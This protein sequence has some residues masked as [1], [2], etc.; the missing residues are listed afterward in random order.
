MCAFQLVNRTEKNYIQIN[1]EYYM[2]LPWDCLLFIWCMVYGIKDET[3][4]FL[5]FGCCFSFTCIFFMFFCF[6][7]FFRE[8]IIKMPWWQTFARSSIICD[9]NEVNPKF[10]WINVK[11][12]WNVKY[13]AELMAVNIRFTNWWQYYYFD[14]PSINGSNL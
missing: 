4:S 14:F 1:I 11:I 10:A 6:F 3:T 7:P 12:H 2:F 8:F 9:L 13:I 5:L